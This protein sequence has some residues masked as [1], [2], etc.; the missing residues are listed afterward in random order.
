MSQ[1]SLDQHCCLTKPLYNLNVPF[2]MSADVVPPVSKTSWL[3]IL[4]CEN[5]NKFDK[6]EDFIFC[7]LHHLMVKPKMDGKIVLYM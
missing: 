2:S 7:F 4:N 6:N 3:C 5:V 1:K